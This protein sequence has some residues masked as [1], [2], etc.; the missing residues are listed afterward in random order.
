MPGRSASDA[1][2]PGRTL[3]PP[4]KHTATMLSKRYGTHRSPSS[5]DKFT[6][7]VLNFPSRVVEGPT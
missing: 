7:R 1:H 3:A 4:C 2:Q 5:R 6:Q